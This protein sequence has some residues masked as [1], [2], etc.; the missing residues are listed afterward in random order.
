ME[1]IGET[2]I[3]IGDSTFSTKLMKS[4]FGVSETVNPLDFGVDEV[5]IDGR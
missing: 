1:C 2:P 3:T 4:D 5:N